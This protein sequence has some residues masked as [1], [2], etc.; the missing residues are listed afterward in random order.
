MVVSD[1]DFN[2]RIAFFTHD[3]IDSHLDRRIH[4]FASYFRKMGH[5]VTIFYP[6][7]INRTFTI[8]GVSFVACAPGGLPN[9]TRDLESRQDF[10]GKKSGSYVAL[11]KIFRAS[12]VRLVLRSPNWMRALLIKAYSLSKSRVSRPAFSGYNS[13][14]TLDEEVKFRLESLPSVISTLLYQSLQHTPFD[15]IVG[16]DL[17]GAAVGYFYKS[18]IPSSIFWFDAHEYFSLQIGVSPEFGSYNIQDV[19][20]FLFRSCDHFT[21]VSEG[22]LRKFVDRGNSK[23]GTC[24]PNVTPRLTRKPKVSLRKDYSLEK[25]KILLF[26]GGLG[27]IRNLQKIVRIFGELKLR[28]WTMVLMGYYAS[29]DLESLTSKYPN[30][31]LVKPVSVGKLKEYIADVNVIIIPYPAV[32]PNTKFCFPNKLGDAISLKVPVMF[33]GNLEEINKLNTEYG[34]GLGIKLESPIKKSDFAKRLLETSK[35]EVDWIRI[36][37]EIGW[38]SAKHALQHILNSERPKH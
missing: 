20:L 36:E 19:E 38:S 18:H 10:K 15:L 5:E 27:D 31:L 37:K 30:V 28:N 9:D 23:K 33:N 6:S 14:E 34:F 8:A 12:T 11:L 16:C 2:L 1:E 7:D 17:H 4:D 22:L 35:L 24:I 29:K 32:D 13:R 21:T 3:N 26:H 25:R